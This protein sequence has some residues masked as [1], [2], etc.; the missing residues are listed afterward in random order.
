MSILPK[1]LILAAA[2]VAAGDDDWANPIV[3]K[4]KL[5]SPLVEVTPFVFNDRF[6][7]LENW[8]KQWEYPDETDGS[9]F[10]EDEVRIRD[11]AKDE[12]V[13]IPLIGH[14]LGMAFVWDGRVYVF[15]G[16][17]GTKEKWGIQHI[18]MVH[19][20]DLSE[21][22]EPEV[23]LEAEP[24]EKFFN[25]SVCRGDGRFIMLVETN[26]P[27]WPAFTFKYFESQDLKNWTRVDNALYGVDKYVGG[28]A[29]Y[30]EGGFYYTLYLE[31]LGDRHWETRVTRSRDLIAWED[32]PESRP[33]ATF[34]PENHVHPLRPADVRECNA[35][36]AEIC[37]W[38]GKTRIYYTGG[39]QRYA[40]DLQHAEFD[41]TPRELL[42][43]FYAPAR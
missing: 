16:Y 37:Y 42:E 12:V 15:A 18:T 5:D 25:V 41:G 43:T 10:V 30:Y 26:D 21:W 9:R 7:L 6:Y 3:Y 32:A 8:Q 1:A 29:L 17:W 34:N 14:G 11:V 39:D 13:S 2:L 33:F 36:D 40:G 4:G 28:P 22:S 35:S 24:Q 38:R 27:E 20:D 23:V 19:S 31:A